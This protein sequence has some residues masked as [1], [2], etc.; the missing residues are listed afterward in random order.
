MSETYQYSVKLINPLR[1]STYDVQK[2]RVSM[3][4]RNVSVIKEELVHSFPDRLT[5]TPDQVGYIQPGHGVRG[6]QRWLSSDQDLDDMYSEYLGKKEI[7][8][9]TY[10]SLADDT[11]TSNCSTSPDDSSPLPKTKRPRSEATSSTLSE[12]YEIVQDLKRIHDDKSI[13]TI[14]QL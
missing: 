4:F 11:P 7:I 1:K 3:K 6:K 9:W 5:K 13:Y 12:G 2:F 10:L 14:E 8:L